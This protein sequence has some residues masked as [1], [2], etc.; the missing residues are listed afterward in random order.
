MRQDWM[1]N[2]LLGL[3]SENLCFFSNEYDSQNSWNVPH[4]YDC[5]KKREVIINL[6]TKQIS[7]RI[8]KKMFWFFPWLGLTCDKTLFPFQS[9]DPDSIPGWGRCVTFVFLGKTLHSHSAPLHPGVQM[10]TGK[11]NPAMRQDW[12]QNTLLKWT[13]ISSRGE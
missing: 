7:E 8:D 13:S 11:L 2:T 1:Q 12:M 10:G 4:K 9:S 3:V 6:Q 5:H